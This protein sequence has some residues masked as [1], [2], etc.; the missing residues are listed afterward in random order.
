SRSP[1]FRADS[2]MVPL[3]IFQGA[4]DPRVTQPQAD[5]MALALHARGIP[6]TYLLASNEGH[7]FGQAETGLAVNRATELFLGQCLGGRVQDRV[8]PT[9]EAALGAMRVDVDTLRASSQ[10]K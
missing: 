9:T 2:A 8:S 10:R 3:L 4:N 7:G 5:R 1:L 6:V